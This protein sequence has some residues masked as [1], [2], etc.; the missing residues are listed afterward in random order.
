MHSTNFYLETLLLLLSL[1]FI[2]G[3]H[4]MKRSGFRQKNHIHHGPKVFFSIQS[5]TE[6]R[7]VTFPPAIPQSITL[8]VRELPSS[9]DYADSVS[10]PDLLLLLKSFTTLRRLKISVDARVAGAC[11]GVL[12]HFGTTISG[13]H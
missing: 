11:R 8:C 2:H 12:R 5:F 7:K 13:Q 4:P 10:D 3:P 1:L 9:S 6:F